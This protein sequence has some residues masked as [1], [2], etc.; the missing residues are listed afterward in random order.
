MNVSSVTDNIRQ[1]FGG[2][3]LPMPEDLSSSLR[4][5]EEIKRFA[6]RHWQDLDPE[7]LRQNYDAI[8]LFTPEAFSYYLPAFMLAAVN[9]GSPPDALYVDSI[10]HMLRP[11]DDPATET[12]Q[13]RRWEQLTAHEVEALDQWLHWLEQ[14]SSDAYF[15]QEVQQVLQLVRARH[16]WRNEKT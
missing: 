7:F 1:S 15:K 5:D 6:G 16:W 11:N 4:E 14:T 10:L 8:P 3:A 13:R 9:T 2:R 12:Y